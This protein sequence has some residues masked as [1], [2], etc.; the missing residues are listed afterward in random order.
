M[1]ARTGPNRIEGFDAR[2]QTLFSIGFAADRVADAPD[3]NDETFAFVVP[4]S[5]LRGIDLD[6]LRLSARGRQ[7]EQRGT[8][9]GAIPTAL[10]TAPGRVR[11]AW[12]AAA[13]RMALIRDVRTG[14][15]LS[16]ARGGAVDLSTTSEDLEVTLSDGVK[17]LRMRVRPR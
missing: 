1:P 10:R 14:Q 17:S 5:Q 12:N 3:P 13:S 16:F 9:G 7:V 6:R 8:G 15:I 11:V 2:G 4:M